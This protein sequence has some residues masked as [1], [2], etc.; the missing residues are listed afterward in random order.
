MTTSETVRPP[1]GSGSPSLTTAFV[2]IWLPGAVEPV[3]AGRLDPAGDLIDFTYGRSYL[4]RPNAIP[5]YLP[6]L[7]LRSGRIRP[8]PGLSVAGCITDAGP[9]SW[10]Q[11]V[12]LARHLG[13]L[14]RHSDTGDLG[15]LTYLL[16][17][18]SD[19]I[20]D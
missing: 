5:L 6:E 12:I 10:G 8:G 1:V 11:R 2:W 17:S 20:G 9:D 19:R 14:N 15:T 3:V 13:H 18:G 16:E 7:P 4:A